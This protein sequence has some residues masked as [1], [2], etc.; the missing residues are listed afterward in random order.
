MG[1]LS[2]SFYERD[3]VTVARELLGKLL[4]HQTSE[5]LT[6][7]KIV[8]VEAYLGGNDPGSHA[9]RGVTPRNKVMFGKPG[10]A[11]IYFIY[12]NHFLFN[13]VSEQE[14]KAGAVLIRA[15]EPV[16]GMELMQKRREWQ[17]LRN[18]TNGPGKLTQALEII[19]EQNGLDLTKGNLKI[20]NKGKEEFDIISSTRIGI[21]EGSEAHLRFY[22]AN[23]RFVSKGSSPRN[24]E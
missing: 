2:R 15:L 18:L 3:T 1:I 20:L 23:N 13:V 12:G 14:G 19:R 11:Y 6:S 17:D 21:K 9:S 7:G 22:I 5:G 24:E 10:L 8:E 4:V 16:E